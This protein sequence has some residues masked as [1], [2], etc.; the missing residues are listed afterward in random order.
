VKPDRPE[1]I[2]GSTT[3]LSTGA[4]GNSMS[5]PIEDESMM[6][7]HPSVVEFFLEQECVQ[8]AIAEA[9]ERGRKAGLAHA[10][11]EPTLL[12]IVRNRFGDSPDVEAAARMLADWD[13]EASVAAIMAAP[14]LASLLDAKRPPA[15]SPGEAV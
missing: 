9:H 7:L 3:R 4:S 15:P 8:R 13:E 12:A 2:D 10:S 11:R 14:D 1:L 5:N 6:D